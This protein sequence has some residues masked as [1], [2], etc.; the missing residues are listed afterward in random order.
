MEFLDFSVEKSVNCTF[1]YVEFRQG[2]DE[3]GK[4]IGRLCGEGEAGTF[5]TPGSLWVNSRGQ[6]HLQHGD[7]GLCFQLY[8]LQRQV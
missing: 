1:D 7:F 5:Q 8:E 3:T 4:L 6:G 2:I